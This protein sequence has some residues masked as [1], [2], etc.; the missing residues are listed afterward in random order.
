M[1]RHWVVD[2]R[3]HKACRYALPLLIVVQAL[4]MYAWRVNPGVQR[5]TPLGFC[6][7][8]YAYDELGCGYEKPRQ[9]HFVKQGKKEG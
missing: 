4:A 1:S 9:V 8:D 5:E 3:L 6:Y 2:G 7:R